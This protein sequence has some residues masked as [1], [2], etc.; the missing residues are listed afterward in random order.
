PEDASYCIATLEEVLSSFPGVLLNLDVKKTAPEVKPYEAELARLLRSYE[1]KDD[2]IV[3]SFS[4]RATDAFSAIAPEIPTSAG[5]SATAEL[6]RA[7]RD[8]RGATEVARRHVAVQV[9]VCYGEVVVVD[10][11]FVQGA[12]SAGLA[13]HVWTIDDATEMERLL[14][15]GVDG[16]MTDTPSVLAGV[17][18]QHGLSWKPGSP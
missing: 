2:V 15:L 1:R 7:V 10:E 16:I 5:M 14:D 3:A 12:H 4:D 6:L 8:G 11:E 9:P 17:L 13:V 18:G